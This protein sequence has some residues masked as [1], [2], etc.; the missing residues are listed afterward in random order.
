MKSFI[1]DVDGTLLDTQW[2]F[3]E[4]LTYA[5]K[6]HGVEPERS[7]DGLFGGTLTGT[8]CKLGLEPDH[9]L[10]PTWEKRFDELS[11]STSFYPGV[12]ETFR[13]LHEHG[14]KILLVTSRNHATADP[15]WKA[16]VLSPYIDFCVATED[17]PRHKPYPDPL[18]YAIRHENLDPGTTI[19]VGDT[20][21]DYTAAKETGIAF[22]A[23]K[24]N[25]NASALPGISL[26]SPADLL[27]LMENW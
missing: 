21:N 8:L 24:W 22:G 15:I 23:A 26:T 3:Y 7:L 16:S 27:Q 13:L 5:L 2:V 20:M 14:A 19:Y 11:Q 18:L 9:P 6:A 1:F 17:T 10:G 4:S 25:P 12:E